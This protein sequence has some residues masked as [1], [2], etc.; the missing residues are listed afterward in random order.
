[1][2]VPFTRKIIS[3]YNFVFDEIFSSALAYNSQL[4]EEAMDMLPDVPYTPY[5]AYSREQSGDI[6]TFAQF[7][8]VNLLS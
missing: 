1:M 5:A 6:I 2:Y 4:Y 3:S 8:E 7:E